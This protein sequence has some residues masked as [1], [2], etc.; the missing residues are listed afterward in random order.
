MSVVACVGI[1]IVLLAVRVQPQRAA[2]G[3]KTVDPS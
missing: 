2:V 3:G 1:L